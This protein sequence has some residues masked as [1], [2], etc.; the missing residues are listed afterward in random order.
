MRDIRIYCWRGCNHYGFGLS[1][2]DAV[3]MAIAGGA[4]RVDIPKGKMIRLPKGIVSYGIDD[5]G[6]V[7]WNFPEG[8]VAADMPDCETVQYSYGLRRYLRPTETPT[9]FDTNE[10]DE[11]LDD[12]EVLAGDYVVDV[13][14]DIKDRLEEMQK[15]PEVQR[16]FLQEIAREVRNILEDL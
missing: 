8:V 1:A 4:K 16:L 12:V 10:R 2:D 5:M 3:T 14:Y 13:E 11:K 6:S 9:E 7:R 15:F